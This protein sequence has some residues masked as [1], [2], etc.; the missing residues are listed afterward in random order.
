MQKLQWHTEQVRWVDMIPYEH[1]ARKMSSKQSKNLD[2]SLTE[3]DVVDIPVLDEGNIIIGG[4][5]R[6]RMMISLGRGDE[7]TDV[8]KPNRKLTEHEFKKLNLT[9]NAIK[10]DFVDE[11]LRD[12]F[13]GVVDFDDFDIQL[14]DIAELHKAELATEQP[15]FPVVP[16]MSEKYTTFVIVC[17]NE[18]DENHIAE[19][20]GIERGQ[21]YKSSKIGMMHVIDSQ[22]VIERWK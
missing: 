19:K 18:I 11:I 6:Q 12:H 1:N 9:L 13:T 4:H 10:G 15:E 16:K 8:R 2:E 3:F 21:C 22:K 5:Q 17:R 14:E 7:F 20:L